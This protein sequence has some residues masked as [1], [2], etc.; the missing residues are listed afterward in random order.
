MCQPRPCR[1][2]PCRLLAAGRSVKCATTAAEGKD[3]EAVCR[4]D[5]QHPPGVVSVRI[6]AE[7][8]LKAE[9]GRQR[10]DHSVCCCSAT[11]T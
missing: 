10:T 6:H 7:E 11:R 9:D 8:E 2:K 1:L 4:G 3:T 5:R